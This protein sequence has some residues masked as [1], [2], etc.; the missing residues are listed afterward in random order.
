MAMGGLPRRGLA[1]PGFQRA[2]RRGARPFRR[3]GAGPSLPRAQPWICMIATG[4]IESVRDPAGG[5][6]EARG[7]GRERAR[8]AATA[9]GRSGGEDSIDRYPGADGTGPGSDGWET[10]PDARL[11]AAVRE[12]PPDESALDALVQRHWQRLFGLCQMLTLNAQEAGDLAQE[13]WCRILR[14]RRALRPDGNFPAYL[15]TVARNL[16]R[17]SG[18]SARRAG[19]M[20]SG[21]MASL[22]S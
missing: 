15:A 11:V 10:W 20:A 14:A 18:R 5:R 16:W 2:G 19:P 21:R 13:T 17:D 12:D 8:G 4:Q 6:R 22:D 1:R 7:P 9:R 3:P